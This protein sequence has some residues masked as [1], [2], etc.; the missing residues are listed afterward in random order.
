LNGRRQLLSQ[1]AFGQVGRTHR[2]HGLDT[3]QRVTRGVSVYRR[4]RPVVPGVHRLQHVQSFF[5]TDL[6]NDDTVGAHTK[7]IDHELPLADGA[8][9][10]HVGRTRL[11]PRHVLLMKLKLGR[12][13]DR[14][15]PLAVRDEAGEHI[16]KRRL[17]GAGASADQTVQPRAHAVGQKL[18]HLRRHCRQV[19]QIGGPQALRR[20][21]TNRQQ[22][23]VDR[24]RRNDG[25]DAR[26]VLESRVDHRRAVVYPA[27]DAAYDPI[28]D[29]QQVGI[30]L[31]RRRHPFEY[32]L[33]LD[34][35]VL[36]GVDEYV[37]D[38]RIAEQRLE[39]TQA[40][41][42]VQDLGEQRLA[43][44]QVK[45]G[46]FLG[47]QLAKQC[48]DLRLRPATVGLGQRLQV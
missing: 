7:G 19:Y 31:K 21:S 38:V 9:A 23:S 6:S 8:L 37:A 16:E 14:D 22:R 1:R 12:I 13:L 45:R 3:R 44:G 17:S 40:E 36:I 48:P 27:P 39:R 11:Q 4:Q 2:N 35:H 15:N 18:E 5:A 10:F 25:I 43:F 47:E 32:A 46:P 29:P 34:E 41:Y 30:I 24:E 28:D 20:K 42:I 33:P 26:T